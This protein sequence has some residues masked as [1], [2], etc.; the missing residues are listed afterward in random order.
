MVI[1][2]VSRRRENAILS[3]V[4]ALRRLLR[5]A[6]LATKRASV[7]TYEIG[8]ARNFPYRTD[9][10]SSLDA[11]T[12]LYSGRPSQICRLPRRAMPLTNDGK[13]LKRPSGARFGATVVTKFSQ[14]A[15]NRCERL[16]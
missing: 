8:F 9:D 4:R 3:A 15:D 7:I 5:K 2:M 1:M 16:P 11:E 10:S 13:I 14:L 12:T 6:F